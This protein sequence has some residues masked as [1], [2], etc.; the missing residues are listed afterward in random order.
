MI[1]C[2]LENLKF[3][4]L[5]VT[6]AQLAQVSVDEVALALDIDVA[7]GSCTLIDCGSNEIEPNVDLDASDEDEYG[8]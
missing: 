8:Y 4:D 2:W 1:I 3:V 5:D 7:S 6:F